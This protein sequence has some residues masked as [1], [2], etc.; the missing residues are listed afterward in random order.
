MQHLAPVA[1][2]PGLVAEPVAGLADRA[3]TPPG[4]QGRERDADEPR[5]KHRIK[6][7]VAASGCETTSSSRI[8]LMR[9]LLL[10]HALEAGEGE[11]SRMERPDQERCS[12]PSV[13]AAA[14]VA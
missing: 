8:C 4:P 6:G 10:D 2:H 12:G 1:D 5:Q 13:T 11:A 3:A 7:G 9:A 14:T